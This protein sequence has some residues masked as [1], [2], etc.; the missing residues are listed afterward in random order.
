[1]K[2]IYLPLKEKISDYYLAQYDVMLQQFSTDEIFDFTCVTLFAVM[3]ALSYNHLFA[4]NYVNA[5][6]QSLGGIAWVN[7]NA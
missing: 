7:T 6:R 5:R 4:S 1:L 2:S 3:G